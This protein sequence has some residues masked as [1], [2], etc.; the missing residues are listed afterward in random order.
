MGEST[1]KIRNHG[2]DF[3]AKSP[4]FYWISIVGLIVTIINLPLSETGKTISLAITACGFIIL[5]SAYYR[6]IP[7][8]HPIGIGFLIMI[9]AFIATS[10][11]API[12]DR[13]SHVKGIHN[14]LKMF[15]VFIIVANLVKTDKE[16]NAIVAAFFASLAVGELWGIWDI[17]NGKKQGLEI[18]SLGHFNHTGIYLAIMLTL[19]LSVLQLFKVRNLLK[20]GIIAAFLLSLVSLILTTSRG[21]ILGFLC[22][23]ILS[24][25]IMKDH[26]VILRVILNIVIFALFFILITYFYKQLSSKLLSSG[27][28]LEVW[29]DAINVFMNSPIFGVGFNQYNKWVTLKVFHAHSLYINTLVQSGIVGLL[30]L[31]SLFWGFLKT[32]V[33]AKKY[34]ENEKMRAFWVASFGAFVVVA[35]SGIFNTAL[36]SEH[37]LAFSIL[38]GICAGLQNK[39]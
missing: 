35:V 7:R 28:R 10:L 17:I 23:L 5:Y 29:K 32:W 34:I 9:M 36:Q 38:S 26:K 24:P 20:A 1:I 15:L 16:R 19:N 27:L 22:F 18:Y 2:D 11:F 13:E 39:Q 25:F 6:K 30:A 33:N 3:S 31:M 21:S 12:I 4:I 8:L 37:G 14:L